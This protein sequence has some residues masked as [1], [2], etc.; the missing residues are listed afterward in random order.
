MEGGKEGGGEKEFSLEHGSRLRVSSL[1][2]IVI[3]SL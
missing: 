1:D 2:Q 3:S